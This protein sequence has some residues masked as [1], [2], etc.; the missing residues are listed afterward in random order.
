MKISQR[1]G[2]HQGWLFGA[3]N[4]KGWLKVSPEFVQ[5][6]IFADCLKLMGLTV[7][8]TRREFQSYAD[9]LLVTGEKLVPVPEGCPI[10]TY[11]IELRDL[12]AHFDVVTDS[13]GLRRPRL[14]RGR[15]R[16]FSLKLEKNHLAIWNVVQPILDYE[17]NARY[18][19]NYTPF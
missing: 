15:E 14:T 10:P 16:M 19:E 2:P 17:Q 12:D 6:P 4:K 1:F 3:P 13:N 5:S 7:Q 18:E 11:F 8:E 9:L